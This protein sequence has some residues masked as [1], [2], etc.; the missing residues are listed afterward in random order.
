MIRY[1]DYQIITKQYSRLKNQVLRR[2]I[3]LLQVLKQDKKTIQIMIP[4]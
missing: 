3:Y 4:W 1:D 2:M